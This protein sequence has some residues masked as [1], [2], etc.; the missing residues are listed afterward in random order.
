MVGSSLGLE[1]DISISRSPDGSYGD[2]Q[3]GEYERTGVGDTQLGRASG[4]GGRGGGSGDASRVGRG[5]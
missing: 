3:D 5:S 4:R 2:I 1:D